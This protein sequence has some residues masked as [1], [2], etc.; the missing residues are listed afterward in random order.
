MKNHLEFYLYQNKKRTTHGSCRKRATNSTDLLLLRHDIFTESDWSVL[1]DTH[2]ILEI[3]HKFTL[4]TQGKKR[5]GERGVVW[6]YLPALYFLIGSLKEKK[7]HYHVVSANPE[8]S[9]S[10]FCHLS[11]C[12]GNTWLKMTDYVQRMNDSPVYVASC[13]LNPKL[14][15]RFF[16]N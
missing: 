1:K 5:L 9:T 16:E 10:E 6:E 4:R 11:A 12:L 7:R 3:F 8:N 15:W 14:K 2:Q 13:V